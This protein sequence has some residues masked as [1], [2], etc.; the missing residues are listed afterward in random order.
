[1]LGSASTDNKTDL[2]ASGR[3]GAGICGTDSGVKRFYIEYGAPTL[4]DHF[5]IKKYMLE[6]WTSETQTTRQTM[7]CHRL[8]RRAGTMDRGKKPP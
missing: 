3:G 4:P 7:T 1:M 5:V 8:G 2:L 6:S